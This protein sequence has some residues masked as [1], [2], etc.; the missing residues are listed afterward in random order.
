[1]SIL[2][3][4]SVDSLSSV[5]FQPHFTCGG[6][7][8]D[9]IFATIR[10]SLRDVVIQGKEGPKFEQHNVEAP[11][12]WSDTAVT[13]VASKYFSGKLGSPDR[14]S[15]VKQPGVSSEF[16]PLPAEQQFQLQT[17][18]RF[19]RW[20]RTGLREDFLDSVGQRIEPE[21]RNAEEPLRD[22]Q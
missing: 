3:S 17:R 15:S 4:P 12:T 9:D 20:A 13:I 7:T 11:E 6:M 22:D 16:R 21:R 1:M 5:L 14:E 19:L 18:G 2:A 10:W 8:R